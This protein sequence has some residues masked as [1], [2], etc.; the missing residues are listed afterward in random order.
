MRSRSVRKRL[1]EVLRVSLVSI[2][3][4]ACSDPTYHGLRNR[5]GSCINK[6]IVSR[7]S[8]S[9]YHV[10][11]LALLVR[12]ENAWPN[13]VCL[14]H[15]VVFL[16]DNA[17]QMLPTI[18]IVF[19]DF[20]AAISPRRVLPRM[21]LIVVSVS[22][23]LRREFQMSSLISVNVG[24]PRDVEWQGKVVRTAI[25]KRPVP[26]ESMYAG[27]ISMATGKGIL[28]GMEASIAR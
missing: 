12:H 18:T 28:P 1:R 23:S 7:H 24:L 2:S 16:A 25:W 11:L 19:G 27:S 10:F 9:A 13:V 3:L 26:A 4:L 22:K 5:C 6:V 8:S 20:S 21:T 17:G 15:G 14:V